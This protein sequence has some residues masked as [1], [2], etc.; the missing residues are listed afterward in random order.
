MSF[1]ERL[2]KVMR[3]RGYSTK[4]LSYETGISKSTIDYRRSGKRQ[5]TYSTIKRIKEAMGCSWEEL[6]G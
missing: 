6:M 1:D 2:R 4:R 3:E 5:P